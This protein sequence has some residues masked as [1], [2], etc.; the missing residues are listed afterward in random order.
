M[1]KAFTLVELLIVITLIAILS[2]A[3]LATLNPIEQTNKARDAQFKN[4][5]AEVLSA[6]ERYFASQN[7]YP[8]NTTILAGGE[9]IPQGSGGIMEGNTSTFGVIGQGFGSDGVGSTD[10]PLLQ[11]SEIKESFLGKAPFKQ[12]VKAIDMFYAY[13]NGQDTNYVCF[14]PKAKANRSGEM[15]AK[16]KCLD[17]AGEGISGQSETC[18]L[19][20]SWTDADLVPN[21]EKANMMCVPE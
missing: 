6:Y 13:T 3:I 17:P 1:K 15:G 10:S 5:A 16:L 4:D 7:A 2:V 18:Q 20:D 11:T 12:S 8:W 9:T 14:F 21:H 19:A